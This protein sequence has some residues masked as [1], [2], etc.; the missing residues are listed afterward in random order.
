MVLA[1]RLCCFEGPDGGMGT[2]LE[3]NLKAVG[4]FILFGK[5]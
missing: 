4:P 2:P 5:W 1:A 3:D